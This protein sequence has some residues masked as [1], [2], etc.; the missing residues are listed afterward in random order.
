MF[1]KLIYALLFI[2]AGLSILKYRRVVKSWTGNFYWAEKYLGSWWTY[3]VITLIW[4]G[5][6]FIGTLYPFG[7]INFFLNN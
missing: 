5:L 7:W 4:M 6:I 1:I 2:W 3:I